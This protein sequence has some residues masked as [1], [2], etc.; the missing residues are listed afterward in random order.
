MTASTWQRPKSH[1]DFLLLA[2]TIG[3]LVIGWIMVYSSSAIIAW[4]NYHN[5]YLFLKR[6]SFHLIIALMAMALAI[7][8]DYLSIRRLTY[9]LL[10]LSLLLL[11]AVLVSPWGKEAGGARRWLA[12][13][14]LSF[15]P[16][17]LSK[18]TLIIYLA[19]SLT[20]K[21][22]RLKE[23]TYGYLPN[24]IIIGLFCA[25]ILL[26]PDLG[27]ALFLLMIGCLLCFI[28]GTPLSYLFYA[29]LFCLPF[30]ILA[31]FKAEFRRQRLSVFL[32]PWNDPLNNGYQIT[33]S[34]LALGSGGLWG[35][36][37]GQGRQKLFY[38]PDPHTDFVFS[39]IGEELGFIGV[40][41][42]IFLL[43]LLV[44]RGFRTAFR[45]PDIYGQL[46]ATGIILSIAIQSS[47]NLG[48]VVGLL[49]IKGLPFPFIS[50]GGTSLLVNMVGI[51]ILWNMSK[52]I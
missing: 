31:L 5:P 26:Q 9:P 34:F 17:E 46:L 15:Q 12:L 42:I 2:G 45:L 38:L 39:I 25:L 16:S 7:K 14:T 33:Q 49:P 48:V 23:F 24:F 35:M 52:Q 8:F 6:H 4:D 37:L 10:A 36:G 3:L 21:M 40:L 30:I 28:A 51:G 11:L 50:L 43:G 13:G 18:L 1:G 44:W 20:K 32:N 22:G 19:H 27:T 29:A 47:I 41:G